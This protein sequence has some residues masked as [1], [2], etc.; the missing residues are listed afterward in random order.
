MKRSASGFTLIELMI[1]V[2][3]IG[4]LA[5]LAL[6]AYQDYVVRARVSEGLSIAADSKTVVGTSATTVA[7]LQA[8]AL[9]QTPSSSKYVTSTAISSTAGATLGEITITYSAN[10]ATAASGKTLVL[11]PFIGVAALGTQI[12]AGVSGAIDWACQTDTRLTASGRG[13]ATG[14]LGTLPHKY[15]PAECR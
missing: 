2:A 11:S 4:I 10:T 1:V 12:A 8:A 13:M 5:A 9:A 3:I 14:T 6:P 7:D 15:A